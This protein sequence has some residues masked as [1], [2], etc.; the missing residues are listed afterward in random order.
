MIALQQL[1]QI[2]TAGFWILIIPLTAMA[3]YRAYIAIF[4]MAN[5]QFLWEVSGERYIK[6]LKILF[7][8]ALLLIGIIIPF[9]VVIA[10]PYVRFVPG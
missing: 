10:S 8:L 2:I 7:G 1:S 3:T 4:K 5:R 9:Y 6:W